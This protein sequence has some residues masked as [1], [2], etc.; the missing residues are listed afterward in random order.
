MPTREEQKDID[1]P[2]R[3]KAAVE[4]RKIQDVELTQL[5]YKAHRLQNSRPLTAQLGRIRAEAASNISGKHEMPKISGPFDFF[6]RMPPKKDYLQDLIIGRLS[7]P[8]EQKV[9]NEDVA[10]PNVRNSNLFL[11][12]VQDNLNE[13][14]SRKNEL[15]RPCTAPLATTL[16]RKTLEEDLENWASDSSS[17]GTHTPGRNQSEFAEFAY[18]NLNASM[19]EDA[20][21]ENLEQ[22]KKH[23]GYGGQDFRANPLPPLLH[24][25]PAGVELLTRNEKLQ[26]I[27]KQGA[28]RRRHLL[29]V[30]ACAKTAQREKEEQVLADIQRKME[31]AD[32]NLHHKNWKAR[33]EKTLTIVKLALITTRMRNIQVFKVFWHKR[34]KAALSI[35][36]IL[37]K[38]LWRC[39]IA[40][41]RHVRM[42]LSHVSWR[43]KMWL[44]CAR[45]KVCAR[46]VRSFLCDFQNKYLGYV[47]MN[48]RY[49][50]LKLQRCIR[51]FL[52]CK[53]ARLVVLK[54]LW[55][56]E[57]KIWLDSRIEDVRLAALAK[58]Q[59]RI[60]PG[61]VEFDIHKRDKKLQSVV[62]RILHATHR[63]EALNHMHLS[64]KTRTSKMLHIK[65]A[66]EKRAH[67]A[68]RRMKVAD[69]FAPDLS[70]AAED[71]LLTWF[72]ESQRNSFCASII[73]ARLEKV[74]RDS[75]INL[76][77]AQN[78]L[79]GQSRDQNDNT[80]KPTFLLYTTATASPA[81]PHN[82]D[83]RRLY[84]RVGDDRDALFHELRKEKRMKRILKS[85]GFEA[86]KHSAYAERNEA[87]QNEVKA[88]DATF[89]EFLKPESPMSAAPLSPTRS[90][91][92]HGSSGSGG[93]S[94]KSSHGHFLPGGKAPLFPE[95][96]MVTPEPEPRTASKLD[97][98][99]AASFEVDITEVLELREIFELVDTDR[100]GSI[101]AEELEKLFGMIGNRKDRREVEV[102]VSELLEEVSSFNF[103]FLKNEGKSGLALGFAAFAAFLLKKKHVTY[104]TE[105]VVRAFRNLRPQFDASNS[106]NHIS[107]DA[108]IDI[109][110]K[111]G[112]DKL[113]YQ[114]AIRL[115]RDCEIFPNSSPDQFDYD[116]FVTT[117][118]MHAAENDDFTG[119]SHGTWMSNEI[120]RKERE[121]LVAA[122][123]DNGSL[124]TGAFL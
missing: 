26:L 105:S 61:T 106:H 16:L 15:S 70:K 19:D 52:A 24:V 117:M 14:E 58:Q 120:L 25:R 64:N 104:T 98:E 72:L 40:Y 62:P 75:I 76:E 4:R 122:Q 23:R 27:L 45:R 100:G 51:N 56:R 111:Y 49:K 87:W 65:R 35:Q 50:M 8:K 79:L 12:A 9:V 38:F 80:V 7:G 68:L 74:K 99:L 28:N 54:K 123:E 115:V 101:D 86:S 32:W 103:P 44:C 124:A 69:N 29:E 20:P 42:I 43:A 22:T 47:I 97:L 34:N 119:V 67:R 77:D 13:M 31:K 2:W 60:E 93:S 6:E 107:R 81:D 108:V 118:M 90:I 94:P 37:R 88:K 53:A 1:N 48:F 30:Q 78:L 41:L 113:P 96:S 83:L 21:T 71:L 5:V 109:L 110:T 102:F 3:D 116:D 66:A 55:A 63:L 82:P 73:L 121:Q 39:R 95:S 84:E 85:M 112:D 92:S 33:Q 59:R 91:G 57:G 10:S 11:T 18:S 17:A 46:L 89:A 114:E 36:N